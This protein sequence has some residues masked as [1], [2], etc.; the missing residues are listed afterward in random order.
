MRAGVDAAGALYDGLLAVR[1]LQGEGRRR[2]PPPQPGRSL[3]RLVRL[4]PPEG[5]RLVPP[6]RDGR[7]RG[8]LPGGGVE[9]LP[10]LGVDLLA[11]LP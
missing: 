10:V 6:Q 8:E 1:L 5:A 3:G 11:T 7:G 2:L 9:Q 4:L